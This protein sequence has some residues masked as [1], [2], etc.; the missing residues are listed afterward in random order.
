LLHVENF[1]K[2]IR[3]EITLS[4]REEIAPLKKTL[5]V[6]MAGMLDPWENIRTDSSSVDDTCAPSKQDILEFYN[7]Q[8]GDCML[9]GQLP[10]Q[11]NCANIQRAHIWPRHTF[12]KGLEFLNLNN[13]DLNSCR[14]YLILQAEIEFYFDRKKFILLPVYRGD[15]GEF[16]L[17]VVVLYHDLLKETLQIRPHSKRRHFDYL[18]SDLDGRVSSHVFSK[19]KKPFLRLIAQH[20]FCALRNA[21]KSDNARDIDFADLQEETIK[22]ARLSLTGD[23][24]LESWKSFNDLDCF[25][26]KVDD[27]I[28]DDDKGDEEDDDMHE[29]YDEDK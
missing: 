16:S 6:V 3:E 22:L 18:W 27:D 23:K 24:E 14:N 19:A 12:G 11:H 17:K 20:C 4:I 21:M 9:L 1:R 5:N 29:M 2:I 8:N 15:E 26:V 10:D 28:K 7:M 13:A 25:R